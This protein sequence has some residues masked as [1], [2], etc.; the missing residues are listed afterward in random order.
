MVPKGR[1]LVPDPIKKEL[2]QR[3]RTFLSEQTDQ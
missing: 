1:Q 3:I 2:L